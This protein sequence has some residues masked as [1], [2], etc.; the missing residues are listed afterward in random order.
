MAVKVSAAFDQGN[1][2]LLVQG[3]VDGVVDSAGNLVVV[4]AYGWVSAMSNYFPPAL[5]AG[6]GS[7]LPGATARAMT[8]AEK[9]AYCKRL[10]TAAAPA[11]AV[12]TGKSLGIAG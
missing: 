2:V 10:L 4:N 12:A 11:V 5:Y 7:R 3:T 9:L 1:D 8:G 6:D